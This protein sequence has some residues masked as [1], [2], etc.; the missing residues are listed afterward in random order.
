MEPRII[1]THQAERAGVPRR[2]L[3]RR[4]DTKELVRVRQGAY[5]EAR[6]W[7]SLEWWERYRVSIAAV[8]GTGPKKRTFTHQSSAAIW[9]IPFVGQ[10]TPV[11]VL[12]HPDLHGRTRGGIRLHAARGDL[13]IQAVEGLLTTSRLQTVLD[14]GTSV[15]FEAA[16]PSFDHVLKPDAGRNL[17]AISKQEMLTAIEERIHS[18]EKFQLQRLVAFADHRSASPGESYSRAQMYILGFPKPQL[19]FPINDSDGTLIGITDYYWESHRLI[20]EYDGL[21]KYMEKQYTGGKSAAQVLALEKVRED[22][23]RATGKRVSRWVWWQVEDPHA[24]GGLA[25]TLERVGLPRDTRRTQWP[26][27]PKRRS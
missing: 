26:G 20:G 3:A 8:D 14:I 2:Q 9:G 17:P 25:E 12:S 13:D 1:F 6:Y 10:G 19:Q 27:L 22:K 5:I 18:S 15:S 4:A 24:P 21:A 23:L 7:Q 16:V 11:H